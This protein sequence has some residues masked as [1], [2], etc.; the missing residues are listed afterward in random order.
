MANVG[1]I[2]VPAAA[3]MKRCEI[4]V[5]ITGTR[6]LRFRLWLGGLVI[7]FGIWITGAKGEVEQC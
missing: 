6:R 3:A 7:R 4:T 2:K 5:R 1:N